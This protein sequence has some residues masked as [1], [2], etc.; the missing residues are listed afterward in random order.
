[1]KLAEKV[2]AIALQALQFGRRWTRARGEYPTQILDLII[3]HK[4]HSAMA[5]DLALKSYRQLKEKFVDWNEVRIS[6]VHE[7]HPLELK[8]LEGGE[9]GQPRF[10][11]VYVVIVIEVIQAQDM[12][13]SLQEPPGH[14]IADEAGRTGDQDHRMEMSLCLTQGHDPQVEA[15]FLAAACSC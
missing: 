13:P 11:E 3:F 2:R 6:S 1:M 5:A 12:V 8:P 9:L 15:H 4:L 7:I 14:M 10:L